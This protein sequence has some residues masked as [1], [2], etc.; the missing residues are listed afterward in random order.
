MSVH[1]ETTVVPSLF[2]HLLKSDGNE[3]RVVQ[4]LLNA[5]YNSWKIQAPE[6]V[7]RNPQKDTLYINAG[8]AWKKHDL[9]SF[10]TAEHLNEDITLFTVQELSFWIGELWNLNS[11]EEFY[12]SDV[13][14]AL[15]SI[16]LDFVEKQ[17]FYS[18]LSFDTETQKLLEAEYQTTNCPTQM[19]IK[20]TA[21]SF[22]ISVPALLQHFVDEQVFPASILDEYKTESYKFYGPNLQKIVRFEGENGILGSTKSLITE[23]ISDDVKARSLAFKIA[24][25]SKRKTELFESQKVL[26][27]FA[28]IIDNS[29]L[30]DK[31]SAIIIKKTEETV[32][33][34]DDIKKLAW[35]ELLNSVDEIFKDLIPQYEISQWDRVIEQLLPYDSI[36]PLLITHTQ[37]GKEISFTQNPNEQHKE[38]LAEMGVTEKFK[39]KF[40]CVLIDT[41]KVLDIIKG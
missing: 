27:E 18:K 8:V 14:D 9:R 5:A 24:S 30:F 31:L 11:V 15:G 22:P 25:L 37:K 34:I 35:K 17:N 16:I 1:Q 28:D 39:V 7:V 4:T 38:W 12:E 6:I 21:V 36:E 32:F 41:T 23:H 33:S 26:K 2:L 10:T 13:A 20:E 40:N 19:G 29:Y 3:N